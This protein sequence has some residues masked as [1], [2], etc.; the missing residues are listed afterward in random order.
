MLSTG[1]NKLVVWALAIGCLFALSLSAADRGRILGGVV[2][3]PGVTVAGI[4]I[5]SEGTIFAGDLLRTPKGGTALVNFAAASQA[6]IAEETSVRFGYAGVNPLAQLSLGTMVTTRLSKDGLIVE[7]PKYRIEPA[8]QGKAVHVV[9][10]LRDE[11][12]VVTARHGGV[13]ITEISSGLRYVLPEGKYATI[14]ASSVGVPRPGKEG[15]E[16][17]AA[18]GTPGTQGGGWHIGSLSHAAS[19]AVVVTAA[20]GATAAIWIPLALASPSAP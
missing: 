19:I 17:A 15:D 3:S 12:T 7:T 1:K 6:N 16:Q 9:A 2:A 8:E 18:G 13:S 4:P 11:G 14:A 5:P 10:V 20:A